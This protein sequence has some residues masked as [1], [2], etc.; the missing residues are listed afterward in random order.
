MMITEF[1]L[2]RIEE[3]E[4]AATRIV[5][6]TETHPMAT[7][8]LPPGISVSC[9]VAHYRV[10]KRVQAECEAKR[11]IVRLR[12]ADPYDCDKAHPTMGIYHP[13]GHADQDP[14]LRAL[15]S[16]YADHPDYRE[17]WRA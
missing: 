13:D 8:P 5:D 3:D 16:V 2:A 7:I 10:D 11:R 14:T 12:M 4:R 9:G 17:E 15:A 6:C 1:L